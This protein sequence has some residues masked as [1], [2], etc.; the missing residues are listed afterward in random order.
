MTAP[1]TPVTTAEASA[2]IADPWRVIADA[3]QASYRTGDMVTGGAFVARITE[4]AEAADHHPDIDLRY[5]AVHLSLSTHSN[6][7]ITTAD[8]ALANSIAAI[9]AELGLTAMPAPAGRI[10]IAID[11]LDIA[12]IAPFWRTVLGYRD[13]PEHAITDLSDSQDILPPIWFQQ[14]DEPRPQRNRIHLDLRLP[15]E[16]VSER[17][18]AALAAG[19]VLVTDEFAPAWWILADVEGNEVCLCTWQGREGEDSD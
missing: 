9:A 1:R 5:G 13:D 12:A 3:L 18:D 17:L 8:V 7:R 10:E 15:P 19:G 16:L 14:M 4:A 11:A 2:A 6:R